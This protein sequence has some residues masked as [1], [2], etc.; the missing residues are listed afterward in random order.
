M[1]LFTAEELDILENYKREKTDDADAEKAKIA[2]RSTADSFD[3][4]P[5]SLASRW[6][7]YL[8]EGD[9]AYKGMYFEQKDALDRKRN[10]FLQSDVLSNVPID[11]L[12]AVTRTFGGS[13][14]AMAGKLGGMALGK[15]I[16]EDINETTPIEFFSAEELVEQGINPRM[17]G[18][19]PKPSVKRKTA[20]D[21]EVEAVNENFKRLQG[22]EDLV[23][24]SI[25]PFTGITPEQSLELQEIRKQ[26]TE[27]E[28]KGLGL[29]P[30]QKQQFMLDV[31]NQISDS[32]MAHLE[33]YVRKNPT[34][35]AV[36]K[37]L[38][39]IFKP[40]AKAREVVSGMFAKDDSISAEIWGTVAELGVLGGM[41][42]TTKSVFKGGRA[43]VKELAKVGD[44]SIVKGVKTLGDEVSTSLSTL[45]S[46]MLGKDTFTQADIENIVTQ[47]DALEKTWVDRK[48]RTSRT[49]T[50]AA[51]IEQIKEYFAEQRE[52]LRD[53]SEKIKAAELPELPA[54]SSRV[55]DIK[56]QLKGFTQSV[57][58]VPKTVPIIQARESRGIPDF[59]REE[60]EQNIRER[61]LQTEG[62]PSTT[63]EI[64]QEA[65]PIST[66]PQRTSIETPRP[67]ALEMR[68]IEKASTLVHPEMPKSVES[69]RVQNDDVKIVERSTDI[70]SQP[71][72]P[73][74][75][76]V[77]M[78][79]SD[80]AKITAK[81]ITKTQVLVDAVGKMHQYASINGKMTK[82]R[83]TGMPMSK[84]P[85]EGYIPVELSEGVPQKTG[86]GVWHATAKLYKN[87]NFQTEKSLK[88]TPEIRHPDT[89]NKQV[90]ELRA[91][92]NG[93]SAKISTEPDALYAKTVEELSR[94]RNFEDVPKVV[95]TLIQRDADVVG[96]LF[97]DLME[98]PAIAE[99]YSELI[100]H[101]QGEKLSLRSMEDRIK[102]VVGKELNTHLKDVNKALD[103]V[104]EDVGTPEPLQKLIK[105]DYL[106]FKKPDLRSNAAR[107]AYEE[108]LGKVTRELEATDGFAELYGRYMDLDT[109]LEGGDF[110][111]NVPIMAARNLI[112]RHG[113][114]KAQETLRS[115][116]V[117][118]IT[119]DGKALRFV[120]ETEGY[121]LQEELVKATEA[122]KA[123]IEQARIDAADSYKAM[124]QKQKVEPPHYWKGTEAEW[125]YFVK[126]VSDVDKAS[127]FSMIQNTD[128][129]V[130]EGAVIDPILKAY[131]ARLGE[132]ASDAVL[133][134]DIEAYQ[135]SRR[136]AD[137]QALT[138]SK[139]ATADPVYNEI[140]RYKNVINAFKIGFKRSLREELTPQET[141]QALSEYTKSL[142]AGMST[143]QCGVGHWGAIKKL[144]EESSRLG[145]SVS[146]YIQ[147]AFKEPDGSPITEAKAKGLA[148]DFMDTYETYQKIKVPDLTFGIP[149]DRVVQICELEIKRWAD[150]AKVKADMNILKKDIKT[151]RK[152][153][154][155]NLKEMVGDY[156][157][158]TKQFKKFP[159]KLRMGKQ[160]QA[161]YESEVRG[162]LGINPE[163]TPGLGK[164]L[165]VP[166]VFQYEGLLGETGRRIW[167]GFMKAEQS[168]RAFVST[169]T[170]HIVREARRLRLSNKSLERVGNY[171]TS[172]QPGGAEALVKAN[173]KVISA[174]DLTEGEK[175]FAIHAR[176][177]FD[178]L[179]EDAENAHYVFTGGKL[180]KRADY[181]TVLGDVAELYKQD[182]SI[183]SQTPNAIESIRRS[184]SKAPTPGIVKTATRIARAGELNALKVVDHYA[185]ALAHYKYS[186]PLY[187]RA[188]ALLNK[189][190]DLNA[191]PYPEA[192][193]LKAEM[194]HR[195]VAPNK[196]GQLMWKLAVQR[197]DSFTLL[198]ESV[199]QG[200]T[201]S[202]KNFDPDNV[203]HRFLYNLSNDVAAST[204]SLSFS[205][206]INQAGSIPDILAGTSIESLTRGII[207]AVAN[208]R[209]Y[210]TSSTFEK[211]S[212]SFDEACYSFMLNR[213]YNSL[214]HQV[215][216]TTLIPMQALDGFVRKIAWETR[217]D[218]AKEKLKLSDREAILDADAFVVKSQSHANFVNRPKLQA[219]FVGKILTPLQSFGI[220]QFS[221]IARELMGFKQ[222]KK[223]VFRNGAI[224][225]ESVNPITK[226]KVARNLVAGILANAAFGYVYNQVLDMQAP[227]ADPINA[228][229]H[230]LRR[231]DSYDEALY[232]SLIELVGVLPF[233]SS[234]KFARGDRKH[235]MFGAGIGTGIDAMA[236]LVKVPTRYYQLRKKGATAA[237]AF[238]TVMVSKDM[239]AIGKVLGM[240]LAKQGPA[241]LRNLDKGFKALTGQ[242]FKQSEEIKKETQTD[243]QWLRGEMPKKQNKK[244]N[245]S[246][247]TRAIY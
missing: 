70:I 160:P 214:K 18:M 229:R 126:N 177:W 220:N 157:R 14:V 182:S 4:K 199:V 115:Q 211:Y 68:E 96:T 184:M 114:V 110:T 175:T 99:L 75:N 132:R 60:Y 42:K 64:V 12:A 158:L 215:L 237:Q 150:A 82:T 138:D 41:T 53:V 176:N 59:L 123:T 188:L 167:H 98:L 94:A 2:P 153:K 102:T 159:K 8:A 116:L 247:S 9:P 119:K 185:R 133:K 71:E 36:D 56:D 217:Y 106:V 192:Q 103:R 196:K 27:L 246:R 221:Y 143:V 6:A 54:R 57:P 170:K 241:T 134:A 166:K 101:V 197:P 111:Q 81:A 10:P 84:T 236:A 198:H 3:K 13:A 46:K 35:E 29:Q 109:F 140:L 87:S 95:K 88:A 62:V 31:G 226:K 239:S 108:A 163:Y 207:R 67:D 228:F 40:A 200:Y 162:L 178:S 227:N 139:R 74:P 122:P 104:F 179:L 135:K 165:V 73:N 212:N 33:P 107:A 85:K 39:T 190:W 97:E 194:L 80:A 202:L 23:T 205:S 164:D 206:F 242:S 145:I 168:E 25:N 30:T 240:P 43:A 55:Y 245:S 79:P 7:Q 24:A 34:T 151:A 244:R 213:S 118:D 223:P 112:V 137:E 128:S 191:L 230:G 232:D 20:W 149:G 93:V 172:L 90:S 45:F 5:K 187:D 1:A 52:R 16:Y 78:L 15:K 63:T 69:V 171:M 22:L 234:A 131:E 210:N 146:K 155:P 47:V 233:A 77:Y 130:F 209:A 193:V 66:V 238:G 58:E 203:V 161:F 120:E 141:L 218:Y 19:I 152:M 186:V 127:Y 121:A 44:G 216:S 89:A 169:V 125:S 147:Q 26:K 243:L 17:A 208:D 174:V 61:Q 83:N 72:T 235:Y 32:V 92:S 201:R 181:F 21:L 142:N 50:S 129:A 173:K 38:E 105:D 37:T 195:G 49:S 28:K 225:G 156:Q 144:V 219:D 180:V 222:Y 224:V 183:W 154:D 117:K 204:L 11:T 91:T 48:T 231:T 148:A 189:E 51:D 124:T 113:S 76:V 100:T 65:E 86:G 136:I